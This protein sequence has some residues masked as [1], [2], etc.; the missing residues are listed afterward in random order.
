LILC[1][2]FEVDPDSRE[3]CLMGLFQGKSF[4]DFP[5]PPQTFTIYGVL[6]AGKGRGIMDLTI[7]R[8]ESEDDIYNYG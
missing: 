4:R 2:R 6:F 5:S 3:A 7:S 1:D 8:M